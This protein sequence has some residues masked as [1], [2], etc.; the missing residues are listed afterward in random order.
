MKKYSTM[1][2]I[3]LALFLLYIMVILFLLIIP[4]SYRGHNVLVG[5]LTWGRWLGFVSRNINIVPFKGLTQ[6][7]GFIIA[8][9][10]TVRVIIYLV[11]NFVGF[12]PLGFFLPALF[13]RERKFAAYLITTLMSITV[14]ELLQLI[15]MR[16]SF[17]IDDIILNTAGACIGF[18][19]VG[20]ANSRLGVF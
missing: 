17:D 14:L 4:N 15:T 3:T 9:R 18:F 12:A 11:G 2:I 1:R 5:G 20:K 19:F 8:E 6:Q 13:A 10:N 7:I 16:G